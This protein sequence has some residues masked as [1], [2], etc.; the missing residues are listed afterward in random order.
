MLLLA[1]YLIGNGA[2]VNCSND[3]GETPRHFACQESSLE[4][5]KQNVFFPITLKSKQKANKI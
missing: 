5:G 1:K 4:L 3:D 2:S